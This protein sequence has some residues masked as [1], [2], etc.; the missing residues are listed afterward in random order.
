M[1]NNF[2]GLRCS[3]FNGNPDPRF[4]LLTRQAQEALAC[5]TYGIKSHKGFILLTGEV[6]TGKTTL[7]HVLLDWLRRQGVA[8]AYVFNS[9]LNVTEFLDFMM[10][11]FGVP[12]GPGLKSQLLLKLN[13]WLLE[14]YRAGK[15]AVLI[16]DEAQHLSPD[17]LEEVRLLTNLET[18][19]QKLL[20][21][22]LCG[23]PELEQKMTLSELRQLNQR[24]TLRAK[25][26]ALDARETSSY[27]AR[28]L[29]V[30]GADGR[31][32]FSPEAVQLIHRYSRGIPRLI[33]LLCEHS[34][35]SAFVDG[36]KQVP[37]TSIEDVARE[38]GFVDGDSPM[39]KPEPTN[40]K[41]AQGVEPVPYATKGSRQ[42]HEKSPPLSSSK[43]S[44][45]R[46]QA[47]HSKP[48]TAAVSFGEPACVETV[49]FVCS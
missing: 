39:A 16:V 32:I 20:Q 37:P 18:S 2:F 31:N 28:R 36:H 34:L 8:T 44:D 42:V 23:Q 30:A 22:V 5:L 35:I 14:Q 46:E 25:T 13:H 29:E 3:P 21:I 33:N 9:R 24:I 17:V 15:T 48:T 1:Y 26:K 19:T 49:R 47:A 7:I 10:A 12:C 27:V 43:P 40:G 6:G 41:E 45:N 4:L 38:F 11:D